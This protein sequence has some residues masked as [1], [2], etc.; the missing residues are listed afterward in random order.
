MG[1]LKTV[2][3][4]T[5]VCFF[6]SS[7]SS[8]YAD[9]TGDLNGDGFVDLRD[10]SDLS[11]YWLAQVP[12]LRHYPIA[13]TVAASNA[14][15]EDK[16]SAD[17]VCDGV[18]DHLTIEEA[19]QVILSRTADVHIGGAVRNVYIGGKIE[20]TAGWYNI[21]GVIDITGPAPVTLE[22][23]GFQSDWRQSMFYGA[24]TVFKLNH[25]GTLLNYTYTADPPTGWSC[26]QIKGIWFEGNNYG[27]SGAYANAPDE[28]FSAGI[29]IASKGDVH[30][31][32]CMFACFEHEWVFYSSA[33]GIW[34]DNCDFENNTSS[35][36]IIYL[37]TWSGLKRDWISNC[38]F[39]RCCTA[40]A[41]SNVYGI[42]VNHDMVWIDKCNFEYISMDCSSTIPYGIY[43][44]GAEDVK[45]TNCTF[46]KVCEPAT[47]P[48]EGVGAVIYASLNS[49]SSKIIGNTFKN[50]AGAK[51]ARVLSVN[52]PDIIVSNN[53]FNACNMT[54]D[55]SATV[56]STVEILSGAQRIKISDNIF[57]QCQDNPSSYGIRLSGAKQ[58]SVTGNILSNLASDG[59]AIQNGS[60][61]VLIQG[62]SGFAWGDA[63][64]FIRIDQDT[65]NISI[66]GNNANGYVIQAVQS[67]YFLSVTSDP[68]E[69]V[70]NLFVSGNHIYNVDSP[71]DPNTAWADIEGFYAPG[72]QGLEAVF[73]GPSGVLPGLPM[74]AMDTSAGD[75]TGVL[76]DGCQAGEIR[77]YELTAGTYRMDLTVNNSSRGA[78]H[79]YR[80]DS[81][82]E[83]LL[84][85]WNGTGWVELQK[86]CS[87]TY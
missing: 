80:F 63:S 19:Y 86:T 62:N 65:Q 34:V 22:G 36:G 44:N 29:R 66:L 47:K 50:C 56:S 38:H 24:G 68:Q 64:S 78:G 72:N 82:G 7:A 23:V 54:A 15:P 26:G 11:G 58:I 18:D 21:D 81:P 43:L 67:G 59:I 1:R 69:K 32:D 49:D 41:Y 83:N 3:Y 70:S 51:G 28:T 10:L 84:I 9:N 73:I 46:Y 8:I 57:N 39:A 79:I 2:I 5:L 17:F 40:T 53:T 31:T 4:S 13:V 25:T 55:A 71:F 12:A 6:L 16:A 60:E 14:S 61:D 74:V 42:Y 30:I 76:T 52:C 45:I 27:L 85:L 37:D 20:F 48:D 77:Y 75:I 35:K 33:H 87:D